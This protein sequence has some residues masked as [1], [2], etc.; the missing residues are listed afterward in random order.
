M[1]ETTTMHQHKRVLF[2]HDPAILD[3]GEL[4]AIKAHTSWIPGE[5]IL[6]VQQG[7]LVIA[8]HTMWPWPK[9]VDRD[10]K[11]MGGT[12]L[13]GLRSYVY[14]DSP[15][16]WGFDLVTMTPHTHVDFSGLPDGRSFILKG[17]KAD[18][19]SWKRMFA[20][21][22]TAARALL[23][24][25]HRD[26]MFAGQDIVAREYV[27]LER[28][29]WDGQSCPVSL[30]YRVFVLDGVVVSKEFY[31]IAED[32]DVKP[33]SADIIPEAFLAEAI[34]RLDGAI[35]WYTLDVARTAA[36]DWIV[37]EISD[38]QRAGLSENDP[39]TLYRNMAEVLLK[40]PIS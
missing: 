40:P 32:L 1:W 22:A 6:D 20:Q 36:G 16:S 37:I 11:R 18:K 38:G 19:S 27:P 34:S 3:P 24:E 9:R 26:P 2:L 33:P 7:D 30:E 4:D 13:N 31:W 10:V 29:S 35:R 28:L 8:R 21:D 17:K 5:S 14:A 23:V 12:L 25:L 39:V 15:L